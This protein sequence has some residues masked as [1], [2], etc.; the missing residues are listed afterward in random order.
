MEHYSTIASLFSY[1][2]EEL[3]TNVAEVKE[4]VSNHYPENLEYIDTFFSFVKETPVGKQTEYYIKTFDVQAVC[5]L[6][7]GYILFGEDYKRGEFLVNMR[8]EHRDANNDCGSELAD[9]LPNM[10]RLLPKIADRNFAEELGYCIMIPALK[11]MLKSFKEENN[12]YKNNLITLLNIM[13]ADFK[14]LDYPQFII[15]NKDKTDFLKNI[16][17]NPKA[18]R[19]GSFQK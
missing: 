4:I 12:V 1:P 10:L 3:A 8:K 2:D 6:D 19:S 18:C 16:N 5:Y 11:E 17:C 9:H 15:N 14:D 7:I 13:E